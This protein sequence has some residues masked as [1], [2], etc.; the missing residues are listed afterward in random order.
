MKKSSR[1]GS[2]ISRSV[3]ISLP[4]DSI[5]VVIALYAMERAWIG[6]NES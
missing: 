5:S 4:L 6:R 1:I 2:D 3:N